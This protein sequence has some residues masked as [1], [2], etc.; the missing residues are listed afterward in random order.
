MMKPLKDHAAR[1]GKPGW[2]SFL[3]YV[4]GLHEQSVR[5]PIPAL[6]HPWEEIGPG[7]CY[8][9]A[10]GHWD[11][12]HA[13]LDV[14]PDCPDHA[15][16]Q[17]EN[18]LSLMRGDGMLP[19]VLAIRDGQV[20]N[21]PY[22]CTHPPLWPVA[23]DDYFNL[24]GN[25]PFLKKAFRLLDAQ[26]EWFEQNRK[27]GEGYYYLD[28]AQHTW[29]SGV[30]E[31]VRFD[32]LEKALLPCVDATAHVHQ[33]YAYAGL[34]AEY[35]GRAQEPFLYRAEQLAAYMRT[36][37]FDPKTGFFHDAWAVGKPEV[38]R[39][40]L[41]GMWPM[42]TGAADEAQAGRVIDE[43]LLAPDRFFTAHPLATV[44]ACDPKFELRMW[45]GPAWNSMTYWAARGCLR[46]N[47]PDAAR[48]ILERAL[49][50]SAAVFE[51]TGTVWEF[52]H[53]Q[54]G[55]PMTVRRKPQTPFNT[56][57]RDYLGHN[58]VLAMARL[59]ESLG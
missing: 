11:L 13:V 17:L 54:G 23:V 52:Y 28:I 10:F 30:D 31:G 15:L 55:D 51:R 4:A 40:A 21:K 1:L 53:P 57:S 3:T 36:R 49:D 47:R 32:G 14:L 37:L 16:Q 58:P 59:W 29:E 56:P 8:A 42:L 45:R 46:Y 12:L 44:A 27:A 33:L 20:A 50:A 48:R 24:T 19:G 38:R 43:N 9:P 18:Y 2:R 5:A 39:L 25:V 7:Y 26:I 6:P 34:W 35:A 22:L 41:E